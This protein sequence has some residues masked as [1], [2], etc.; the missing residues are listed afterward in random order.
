MLMSLQPKA[1]SM[2]AMVW[3]V[4]LC[5]PVCHLEI[6]EFRLFSNRAKSFWVSPLALRISLMRSAIPKDKSNSAFCSAG[7]AARQSRKSLFCII[8]VKFQMLHF[9]CLLS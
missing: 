1:V 7:I 8:I 3:V 6:S 4:K 9:L 2:R 5:L